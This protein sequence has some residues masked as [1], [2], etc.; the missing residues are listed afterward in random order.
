[1]KVKNVANVHNEECYDIEIKMGWYK[2]T[3]VPVA[4]IE[5]KVFAS[6]NIVYK[7]DNGDWIISSTSTGT[8]KY[9]EV[10]TDKPPVEIESVCDEQTVNGFTKEVYDYI[11]SLRY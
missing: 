8:I 10:V 7:D 11:T 4:M 2:D 1:M 9:G 5:G 3:P 6:I